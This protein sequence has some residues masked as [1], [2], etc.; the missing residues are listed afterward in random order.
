MPQP[1]A[2]PSAVHSNRLVNDQLVKER[3]SSS[4]SPVRQ[5]RGPEGV[6]ILKDLIVHSQVLNE[7]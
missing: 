4:H 1:A 6:K 7:L 5:N 2:V 3:Q